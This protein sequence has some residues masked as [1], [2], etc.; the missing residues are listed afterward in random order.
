MLVILAW[1][2]LFKIS[3]A[4]A[5][6]LAAESSSIHGTIAKKLKLKKYLLDLANLYCGMLHLIRLE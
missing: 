1:H 2:A 5:T 6:T 4:N 3:G